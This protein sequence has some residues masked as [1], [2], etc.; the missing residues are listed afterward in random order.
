LIVQLLTLIQELPHSLSTSTALPLAAM[1]HYY[2][3]AGKSVQERAE[4]M[5]ALCAEYGFPRWLA[6]G[7]ILRGWALAA[8][9]QA[10]AGI[11]QMRQGLAAWQAAD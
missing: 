4:V 5:I 3:H 2:L 1:L 7:T 6:G 9:G 11:A 8:Q 10:E